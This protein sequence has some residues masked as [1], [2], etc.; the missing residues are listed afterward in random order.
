MKNKVLI[1]NHVF[2]PDLINTA[3]HISELSEE[4]VVRGWDVTALITNRSY[5]DSSKKFF[6]KKGIKKIQYNVIHNAVKSLGIFFF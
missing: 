3:R 6:P 4:L 1:L 5:V 2:W